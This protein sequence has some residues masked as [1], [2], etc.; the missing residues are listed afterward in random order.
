MSNY[1]FIA[2]DD[3]GPKRLGPLFHKKESH[4]LVSVMQE[5]NVPITGLIPV[6][7]GWTRA[8]FQA[9][10]SAGTG[11]FPLHTPIRS[12]LINPKDFFEICSGR[13]A[14]DITPSR[15]VIWE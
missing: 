12:K 9:L 8:Q 3:P 4:S 2:G 15:R 1:L 7:H 14:S 13:P 5:C 11:R 10:T 6:L